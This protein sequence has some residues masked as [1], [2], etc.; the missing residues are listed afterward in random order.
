MIGGD[1]YLVAETYDGDRE[2]ATA[3]LIRVS[4]DGTVDTG[5][6]VT[7]Q[8]GTSD[9][10]ISLGPDG[11]GYIL[12]YVDARIGALPDAYVA[13]VSAFGLDGLR[14][15]WPI[16]FDSPERFEPGF[17]RDGQVAFVQGS[18]GRDHL[19][20]PLGGPARADHVDGGAAGRG[21]QRLE[22]G[23][24]LRCAGAARDR[25]PGNGVRGH[26][27]ST[28]IVPPCTPSIHRGCD[29][30]LETH[31]GLAWAGFCE[32]PACATGCGQSGSCPSSATMARSTSPWGA[33]ASR[34]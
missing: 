18:D 14:P 13:T 12:D 8:E 19:A 31:D 3:W 20:A 24:S 15:G 25:V 7:T 9:I 1:L 5:K 29:R 22:R 27:P 4:R 17:G 10:A 23:G 26:G 16:Q 30:A 21:Q 2:S 6:A 32:P 33:A 11:T 34:R 28:A